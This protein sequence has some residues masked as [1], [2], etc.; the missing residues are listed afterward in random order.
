MYFIL[1]IILR[2]KVLFVPIL[3]ICKLGLRQVHKLSMLPKLGSKS[4]QDFKP[5]PPPHLD[6][7][8]T[9]GFLYYSSL[10]WPSSHPGSMR[11]LKFMASYKSPR[12]HLI[13]LKENISFFSLLAQGR[14]VQ[15]EGQY[16]LGICSVPGPGGVRNAQRGD[17]SSSRV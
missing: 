2:A 16:T 3:Q 12:E 5:S 1:K 4:H 14:A 15:A 17:H 11:S 13:F 6:T 10:S 8:P 9:H 7:E